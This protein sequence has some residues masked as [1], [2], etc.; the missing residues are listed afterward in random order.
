M[1]KFAVAALML[2]ASSSALAGR[3]PYCGD[4]ANAFGP[5][6]Y[7]TANAD[8]R[9]IVESYHFT[10][11]V[12]QLVKGATGQIA[13]DLDYTLRAFPNHARALISLLKLSQRSRGAPLLPGA[14]FATECY[15]ERAVRFQPDDA[16][17]WSLYAQYLYSAGQSERALPMLQKAAELAPENPSFSYNLGLAYAKR[18]QFAEALPYAQKA[19]AADFPLP[20][21]R[22]MLINAGKWQE[23]VKPAPVATPE[24]NADAKPDPA[25]P[26]AASAPPSEAKPDAKL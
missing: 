3:G 26:A 8:D 25:A 10:E 12:E 5:W 23:P 21:L 1:N 2:L 22:Q 4:I 17:A 11:D 14:H 18:K 19:Y 13:S 16:A 9:H 20:G 24:D 6:D 15:F 7:R